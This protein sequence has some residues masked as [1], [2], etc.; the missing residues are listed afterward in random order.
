M[1]IYTDNG[2]H[3]AGSD[4]TSNTIAAIF[5]TDRDAR[6]AIK[7]LHKA[8]FKKTWLGKTHAAD[9]Q[10]GD[11][12]VEDASGGPIGRFF[13]GNLTLR[14]ALVSRGISELQAA[15]VEDS[16]AV[17]CSIVTVYGEDN[18]DRASQVLADFKGDVVGT[19][20]A[21]PPAVANASA[22]PRVGVSHQEKREA[23]KERHEDAKLHRDR[24]TSTL[25]PDFE[26]LD[27]EEADFFERQYP[28]AGGI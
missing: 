22:S 24:A 28:N 15:N 4:R 14:R 19:A 11:T 16:I 26:K 1:S 25:P 3:T 20:D 9:T 7:E 6:E 18:P 2:N 5:A 27:L 21:L 23:E 12:L 10:T 8:G 13:A 17:G